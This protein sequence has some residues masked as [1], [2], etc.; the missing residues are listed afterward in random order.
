[1]EEKAARKDRHKRTN[2]RRSNTRSSSGMVS[3][4]VLA[5]MACTMAVLLPWPVIADNYLESLELGSATLKIVDASD[6]LPSLSGSFLAAQSAGANGDEDEAIRSY[7]RA[8]ELDPENQN[9]KQSLF[10][11]LTANGEISE[12]IKLLNNIPAESQTQNINH[13]V[14]AANALKQKSWGQALSR[15]DRV[16]GTD[17]DGMLATI[18]GSWALYG[19]R[20]TDE[21]LARIDGMEGPDWVL[22]IREYHAGLILSAAGR[23][24]EAIPRFQKAVEYR[25]VAAALTET[26]IRAVEGLSRAHARAGNADE[27]RKAA[28]EGLRLLSD[29]PPLL[30][31]RDKLSSADTKITPLIA[32]PQQ[33]GAE[34]FFNVGTAISRQGGLPFAQGHLQLARFLAP[35][36]DVVHFALGNVYEDQDR[37]TQANA[38]Y[39]EIDAQSPY[40]RR[41]QLEYAL[42]LNRLEQTPQ[43]VEILN[44][45]VSE[46]PLD[47]I[48]VLSLGGVHAQH[49]AYDKAIE[50][51]STAADRLTRPQRID[52]RLF[53]RRGI[54]YERTKQW[55]KAEADFKK[56]L[57]LFPDQPDVLNYLGYSWIDQGINLDEGLAMVRK[58]VELRP[59]S[60]FIIDSL[61]WAY[62]RLGRFEEA[63]EELQK[64]L[65]L[66]PSDPVIN[67]HLG[68]AYWQIG[69]KLEAVF[70][71]KHALAGEPTAEDK[72][73]IEQKLQVGLTH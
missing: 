45:L 30:A 15:I 47:M 55:P 11:A 58:A 21:A 22:M 38:F 27:A 52:W 19:D 18:F 64:A 66:M 7:R 24:S 17:L 39:G 44:G 40:Y 36:S 13:V 31:L 28:E 16:A 53:Y 8:V 67:D 65:E 29:Y 43:A 51:Y 60:G 71:W 33:G 9:L 25:A 57:Q 1:M 2:T 48:T 20:K 41:A 63:A 37:Y 50:V 59:N 61:G 62:Y 32:S 23:D 3:L 10:V 6:E 73:K 46:D 14:V 54:A 34:V 56:A 68:D 72:V 70:Q 26:Y 4:S 5:G 35:Q 69:R 12:A 49:D 42:N